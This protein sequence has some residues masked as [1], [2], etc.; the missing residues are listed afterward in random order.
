MDVILKFPMILP[1]PS[2]SS[3]D[4]VGAT[5]LVARSNAR[6]INVPKCTSHI[7]L[8]IHVQYNAPYIITLS[9]R[10]LIRLKSPN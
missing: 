10:L 2:Y 9:F 8:P 4:N 7:P 1:F 3:G 6:P 5:G